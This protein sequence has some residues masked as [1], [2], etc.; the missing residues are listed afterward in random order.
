M[1]TTA[2]GAYPKP[3]EVPIKDWFQKDGGTDT[4]E[5][6][7]G[8]AETVR[9]YGSSLEAILDR[10]TV[11]IVREQVE[12]GIDVPTDGEL[13]RENYI[14]Y[15]CRHLAGID[16]EQLT[17]KQMRGHYQARL[18]TITGPVQASRQP[19]L[20]R[21][22]QVAQ[23]ATRKPVKI[24]VPGPLTIGD[25]VADDF[26]RDPRT[27][28][29][30]LADALN[31]EIRRLAEAGCPVIQVDE[32]VFA[33]RTEDALAFGLEHL[34]RCFHKLPPATERVVHVCC[35]YPDK[36]DAEDYP[37]APKE[38]YLELAG[39]LDQ[40]ALDAVSIEDAHR[41][42][43]LSL[44]ERF[45]RKTVILGVIAIARSRIEEV[46]EVRDRL[47]A[48]LHHIDGDRL[49]AAPDCGLGLLGRD[50]ARQKLKVLTEAAHSL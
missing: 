47:R 15:H 14:H 4:A 28:G 19:F 12:L 24:T 16:F 48:A 50:L 31:V 17:E 43:D 6:T 7:A 1:L 34:E 46:E 41:P 40:V 22:W 37:K 29:A 33:R 38:A 30:A 13:R 21:D 11:A 39:G 20:V 2:I 32:P 23:S 9:R 5:P 18:P 35:G 26:Y 49:L 36:L 8:Y 44:L 25:S 45:A 27:R 42:N 10:A 3:D